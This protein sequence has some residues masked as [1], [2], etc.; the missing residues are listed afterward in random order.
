MDVQFNHSHLSKRDAVAQGRPDIPHTECHTPEG[1]TT[2]TACSIHPP[3]PTTVSVVEA[4]CSA[5]KRAFPQLLSLLL[6]PR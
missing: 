6:A 2:V 3:Y 5:D 4:M 1:L